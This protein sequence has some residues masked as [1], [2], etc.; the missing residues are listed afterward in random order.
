MKMKLPDFVKNHVL[1][2]FYR[3]KDQSTRQWALEAQTDKEQDLQWK[4]QLPES[5]MLDDTSG[6]PNDDVVVVYT[7]GQAQGVTSLDPSLKPEVPEDLEGP[8]TRADLEFIDPIGPGEWQMHRPMLDLDF[9]A[10]LIPST[11]EGH[12]H[13]YLD[14]P[15]TWRKYKR[16]LRA[17]GEAGIIEH[18]YMQASLERGYSSLRLPWVKKEVEK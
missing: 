12:F 13:L 10:T 17:L 15:M 1:V 6:Y 5:E 2:A 16:L 3:D 4:L 7:S 18:G 14:K 8:L 9:P 11:T